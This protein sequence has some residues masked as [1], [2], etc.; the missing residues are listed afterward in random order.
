[1]VHLPGS[2]LSQIMGVPQHATYKAAKREYQRLIQ[3]SASGPSEASALQ[4]GMPPNDGAPDVDVP[5]QGTVQA[6]MAPPCDGHS[7]IALQT[8]DLRVGQAQAA[9]PTVRVAT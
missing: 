5:G 3:E 8:V 7:G 2:F 6:G 4:P 1:M 9:M